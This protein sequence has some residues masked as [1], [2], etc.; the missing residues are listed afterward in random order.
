LPPPLLL[1]LLLLLWP[2]SS[3]PPCSIAAAAAGTAGDGCDCRPA[4]ISW[5]RQAFNTRACCSKDGRKLLHKDEGQ[6]RWLL[7]LG[8]PLGLLVAVCCELLPSGDTLGQL[9]AVKVAKMAS[10][11]CATR[12]VLLLSLLA[13]LHAAA[14]ALQMLLLI[15]T[16]A[17]KGPPPQS[18]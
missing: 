8:L 14:A 12:S 4:L 10:S 2:M 1:L 3:V 5:S 9:L 13:L 6:Q 18:S 17:S 7:L 11:D 15:T 16:A